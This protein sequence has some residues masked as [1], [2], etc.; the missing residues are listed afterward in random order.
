MT[1]NHRKTLK[2]FIAF[3]LTAA[4]I[5]GAVGYY[6][7]ADVVNAQERTLPGIEQL[8]KETVDSGNTFHILEVVPSRADAS[9][10]Y[11]IGGEEPVSEGRKLS[12][13]PSAA[14]RADV[15]AGLVDRVSEYAGTD[16]LLTVSA[17]TESDSGSRQE[18]IKGNFVQREGG[19]GHYNYGQSTGVYRML[20]AG[21]TTSGKIYR[22]DSKVTESGAVGENS[23]PV[24]ITMAKIDGS[25]KINVKE[26]S[27]TNPQTV[28][29]NGQER[30][31]L[32]FYSYI[33]SGGMSVDFS[34]LDPENYVDK[35]VWL[36]KGDG[37]NASYTYLGKVTKGEN[38][39][40]DYTTVTDGNAGCSGCQKS[41]YIGP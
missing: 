34:N 8:V 19:L 17:Y 30:Y 1:Q 36:K 20:A 33:P 28:T 16:G 2:K 14:E 10:G 27:T 41:V 38:V 23:H 22:R 32:N 31:A 39:P 15:M 21:E 24:Q 13:L 5:A 6:G 35:Q 4:V 3:S 29:A 18:E 25:L 9:I 40:A 37:S 12:E 26:G 11:L 7:E